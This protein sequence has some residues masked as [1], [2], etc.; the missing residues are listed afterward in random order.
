MPPSTPFSINGQHQSTVL[1]PPISPSLS[2]VSIT[3]LSYGPQLPPSQ[4]KVSNTQLSYTPSAPFSPEGQHHSTVICPPLP[5]SQ[6]MVST[7]QLSYAPSL[8]S[9]LIKYQHHSTVICPPSLHFSLKGQ[10]HSTVIC[11]LYPLLPQSSATLH[12]QIPHSSPFSINCQHHSTVI[13]R[14]LPPSPSKVNTTQLPLVPLR[15]FFFFNLLPQMSASVNCRM[16]QSTPSQSKV[17]TIQLSY[18]P[19]L[20]PSTSKVRITQLSHA[21]LHPLLNQRSAP[22]NCH[23]PHSTLFSIKGQ[24]HSTVLCPPF[25]PFSLKGQH[26]STVFCPPLHPS[27][28]KVSTTQMS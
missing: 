19:S 22:L 12:C 21:P 20:L 10:H 2:K 23:L 25:N 13:C 5:T 27:Q 18:V 7:T 8:H 24:H 16:P 17:S 26:H 14:P 1:C 3:Q 15:S 4:S 6:S 9:F 28:S 11:P